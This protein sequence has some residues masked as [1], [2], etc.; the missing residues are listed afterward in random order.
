MLI[1]FLVQR[2]QKYISETFFKKC[3]HISINSLGEAV[4]KRLCYKSLKK[5]GRNLFKWPKKN[6]TAGKARKYY[7]Q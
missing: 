3:K 5:V 7:K 1:H 4:T 2:Q 6:K